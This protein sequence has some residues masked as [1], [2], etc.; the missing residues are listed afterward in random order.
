MKLVNPSVKL[1][2]F[3]VE[4]G[5]DAFAGQIG[6]KVNVE[7]GVESASVLSAGGS[8]V[9]ITDGTDADKFGISG[10]FDMVLFLDPA[11]GFRPGGVNFG[12]F[13]LEVDHLEL[14]IGSFLV[15]KSDKIVFHPDAA[16]NEA[17]LSFGQRGRAGERWTAEPRR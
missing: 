4:F 8:G 7:I 11:N 6:L 12:N 17:L 16:D 15:V 3:G 9:A 5:K 10:S 13:E 2:G 14:S 1:S